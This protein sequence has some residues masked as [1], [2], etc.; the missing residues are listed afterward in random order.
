MALSHSNYTS[1]DYSA[2][3]TLYFLE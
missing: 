1:K 2:R 3:F